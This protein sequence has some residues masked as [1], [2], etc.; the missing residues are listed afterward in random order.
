[1]SLIQWW[2]GYLGKGE[3]QMVLS[4]DTMWMINLFNLSGLSL[5]GVINDWRK[6][7]LGLEPISLSDGPFLLKTLQIPYTY[8]WSPGLVP[9]P[10]DW[11]ANAGTVLSPIASFQNNS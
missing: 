2:I 7:E 5:G 1:M 11:P 8:C 3:L 4:H 9:K 10:H 6:H